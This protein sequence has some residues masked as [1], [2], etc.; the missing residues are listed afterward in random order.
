MISVPMLL[1]VFQ[2]SVHSADENVLLN[3]ADGP[4]MNFVEALANASIPCGVEIRLEDVG[5]GT[6]ADLKRW[7]SVRLPSPSAA[8]LT[9]LTNRFN[10]S[11]EAYSASLMHGVLVVRPSTHDDLANSYLDRP[12]LG[13]PITVDSAARATLQI[14]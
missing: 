13:G 10:N 11:H 6:Y 12:Y 2:V 3:E 5:V 1:L 4:V 14:F 8:F 7:E 9:E